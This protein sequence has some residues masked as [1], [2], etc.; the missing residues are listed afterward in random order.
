M[1]RMR[2]LVVLAGAVLVLANCTGTDI[3]GGP[4]PPDEPGQE[5]TEE[6]P[7]DPQTP[8]EADDDER[9]PEAIDD[10]AQRAGVGY[11]DVEV[12][13][14]HEVTWRDGSIGCPEEGMAYTQALVDGY[15]LL[16]EAG[17]AELSYHASGAEDFFYCADPQEPVEDATT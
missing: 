4:V 13:H 11:D 10:A 3:P 2:I 5:E 12:V 14:L 1:A 8:P 6:P 9:V 17:G 7:E 15:H 16:L